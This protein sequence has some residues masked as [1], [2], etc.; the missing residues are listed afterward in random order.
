METSLE[1]VM[2]D[3]EGRIRRVKENRSA[4]LDKICRAEK[5][6]EICD[7]IIA[8]FEAIL[9][10]VQKIDQEEAATEYPATNAT[11]P[12]DRMLGGNFEEDLIEF[13]DNPDYLKHACVL[14]L[15]TSGSMQGAPIRAL[16]EGVN[17]YKAALERETS[18]LASLRQVETAIVTFNDSVEV[19]QDFATVD[20][21][22]T[23]RLKASG[24]TSTAAAINHA[25]D[26]LEQRTAMYREAGIPYRGPGIVLI[27]YGEST[28]DK[29]QMDEA[30]DRVRDAKKARGLDFLAVRVEVEVEDMLERLATRGVTPLDNLETELFLYFNPSHDGRFGGWGDYDG[31]GGVTPM[32]SRSAFPSRSSAPPRRRNGRRYEE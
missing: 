29:S 12:E 32:T 1:L 6:V 14:L 11:E 2:S 24:D 13:T 22:K 31:T 4:A 30:S 5:D 17:A 26:M 20:A 16:N 21:L 10:H 27:T 15:D 23:P 18:G 7:K 19:V 3:I 9:E 8:E 28:E 25:L